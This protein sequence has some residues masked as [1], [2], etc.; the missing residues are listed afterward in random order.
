[1]IDR[2]H[3]QEARDDL[4]RRLADLRKAR[5][6]IQKDVA[7]RVPTARST[8]GMVECGQ[9]V[10]DRIFWQRCDSLL[11][12]QGQ[13]VA[14][15]DAYQKLYAQ[16][17]AQQAEAARC[18]RWAA[19]ADL[20]IGPAEPGHALA[21]AEQIAAAEPTTAIVSLL[22]VTMVDS[23]ARRIGVD[24]SVSAPGGQHFPGALIDVEMYPA[25]DDGRILATITH[26]AADLRW[27]RPVQRRLV[28]GHV[29]TPDHEG[30]F[31]L[32][33]RQAYRRL[34]GTDQD[35]RLLIPRAYQLDAITTAVLWAVANLDLSLL[36]DDA[37]LDAAQAA[38]SDYQR[39]TR[40]A[41]SRDLADDLDPVS[42]LWLGSTFCADH[43]R[44]HTNILSDVPLY[45]TREQ[46]GEEASTWLLFSHKLHYL[47][48]TAE[49]FR[50]AAQPMTRMF[51]VPPPAV[52]TSS[53]SERI[54][55]LLAVALM[56]S[57]GIQTAITDEPE[58]GTLPGLVLGQRHAIMASWIRADGVWHVDVT[59]QSTQL[60]EYRDALG[61]VRA[62]SVIAADTPADRLRNLADYLDLDWH[63]LQ[64]RC[65]D[66]GQY[67]FAGLAEPRSRLLC[68]DGVDQACRFVGT[69]P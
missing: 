44:R 3:I 12:A 53:T 17:R 58:Y 41:V 13:L 37:R 36:L 15:Y 48:Q 63:W 66:L 39:L 6:L 54:L 24:G 25:V 9:Q 40:S 7:A 20:A 50:N 35:S 29:N 18:A 43:I 46:R 52:A 55:L 42:R 59:N 22:D 21:V 10:V 61:H 23:A 4:G 5:G 47:R 67:G 31:A 68:L 57:L 16:Y 8:Y 69:L 27:R 38:A 11:N 51:C 64:R 32:D 33:S 28:L 56:E 45:W 1:M 30:I 2:Q 19:V 60:A 65:A 62:H 34:V 26:T 14:A 49:H